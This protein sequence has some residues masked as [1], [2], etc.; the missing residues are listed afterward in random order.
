MG[1]LDA[2]GSDNTCDGQIRLRGFRG[3]NQFMARG[4]ASRPKM[5]QS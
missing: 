3:V 4:E 1:Y 2:C 5:E